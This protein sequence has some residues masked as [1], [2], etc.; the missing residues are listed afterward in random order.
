MKAINIVEKIL[1]EN[2]EVITDSTRKKIAELINKE[3]GLDNLLILDLTDFDEND[4]H[5]VDQ[6]L[7]EVSNKITHLGEDVSIDEVSVFDKETAQKVHD[8]FKHFGIPISYEEADN[9]WSEYSQEIE[10]ASYSQFPDIQIVS[11]VEELEE[12]RAKYF[13]ALYLFREKIIFNMDQSN[14]LDIVIGSIFDHSV[15]QLH[16]SK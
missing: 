13:A 14:E 4:L 3:L 16:K 2:L 1:E 9:L 11:S 10:K 7:E 15:C 12:Q 5:N 8:L 6:N